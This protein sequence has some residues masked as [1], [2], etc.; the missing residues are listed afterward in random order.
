V[1]TDKEAEILRK[2]TQKKPPNATQWSVRSVE[3]LGQAIKDYTDHHNANPET[4]VW[5]KKRKTFWK[6]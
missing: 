5:T 1:R 2:T 6:K 4:F 3:P